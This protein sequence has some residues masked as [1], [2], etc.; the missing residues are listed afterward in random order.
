MTLPSARRFS[1]LAGTMQ[2]SLLLAGSLGIVVGAAAVLKPSLVAGLVAL[3]LAVI[4]FVVALERPALAFGGLVLLLGFAPVYSAPSIGPI[5][6]LPASAAAWLL[7]GALFWRNL[8]D[9]G[10]LPKPTGIDYAVGAFVL[11]MFVSLW[12]SERGTKSDLIQMM[13]LWIGPYLAARLLLSEVA[14]PVRVVALSFAVV[15][16]VLTP[17][18]VAESAGAESPFYALDLNSTESAIWGSQVERFGQVRAETS[19]GHPIAFSMFAAASV[20]LSLAMGVA[21]SERGPRYAWYAAAAIAA[22]GQA[23]ALSRTGWLALVVGVLLFAA[24]CAKG[25]L[26]RQAGAVLGVLAVAGMLAMVLFPTELQVLPGTG[27]EADP[28]FASSGEYRQALLE[29]AF[30]PGVLG[31]WGNPVN[32]ITPAVGIGSATDNAYV[33]LADTWGLIPTSALLAVVVLLL[34]TAWRAAAIQAVGRPDAVLP[35][36]AFTSMISLLFVAFIT[37]Q[38]AMIWLLIGAA[39]VVA[40]RSLAGDS[41]GSASAPE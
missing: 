24:V 10:R 4:G 32:M 13:F 17:I 26:R 27:E 29:R 14:N 1:E 9:R 35:I 34:A 38:Q 21:S 40:E 18:A 41:P 6:P 30:E 8:L 25:P 2:G 7:A 22:A 5:L 11:L 31:L 15:A 12:F 16:V 23:L 19:F 3:G 39:A 37:Q 28:I 36:V 20:L 33:V